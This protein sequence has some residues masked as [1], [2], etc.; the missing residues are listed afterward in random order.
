MLIHFSRV[1]GAPCLIMSRR[2]PSSLSK[3]VPF[4]VAELGPDVDPFMLHIYAAVAEKERRMISE[5]T[6]AALKAAKARGVKL[7]NLEQAA[8][9]RAAATPTQRRCARS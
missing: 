9:N 7:G 5:R 2:V 3:R 4:I 1:R 8:T 6:E